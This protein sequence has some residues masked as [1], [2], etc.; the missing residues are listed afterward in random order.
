MDAMDD[1]FRDANW[2]RSFRRKLL[3]WYR[4]SARDLPWRHTYDRYAIWVSEI[5]LQ[6]TQ[7]E[8]VKPYYARFLESFPDVQSLARADESEVLRHW[9]GLGYYRRARQLHA[10]AKTIVQSHEACPSRSTPAALLPSSTRH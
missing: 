10:A 4:R 6:Q 1:S 8:T 2:R 9:E 3:A 5:M 7:V